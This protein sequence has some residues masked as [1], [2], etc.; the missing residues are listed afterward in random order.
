MIALMKNN[1]DLFVMKHFKNEYHDLVYNNNSDSDKWSFCV[2][3][4]DQKTI[5]KFISLLLYVDIKLLSY[6]EYGEC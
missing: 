4:L 3:I 5:I 6:I 1:N 2:L